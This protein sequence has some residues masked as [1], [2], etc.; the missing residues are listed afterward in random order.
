MAYCRNCG[1]ELKD[2]DKFCASCGTKT[3]A[4]ETIPEGTPSAEN[5][6]NVSFDE[7]K[8]Y[9]MISYFGILFLLPYFFVSKKSEFLSFHINQGAVLWIAS[10]FC[11]IPIVGWIAYIGVIALMVMGIVNTVNGEMKELPFIGKYRIFK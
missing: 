3:C 9:A 4:E 5:K 6:S 7:D 2:D 8:L 10:L 1:A 11:L